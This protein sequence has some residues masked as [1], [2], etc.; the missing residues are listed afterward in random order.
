MILCSLFFPIFGLI[1]C[2]EIR[3]RPCCRLLESYGGLSTLYLYR[4]RMVIVGGS[5]CLSGAPWP[6]FAGH[7]VIYWLFR[8]K[9]EIQTCLAI[10]P[11]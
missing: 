2:H 11:F 4:L 7:F 6:A 1:P 3:F 10:L 8:N 9:T 5:V